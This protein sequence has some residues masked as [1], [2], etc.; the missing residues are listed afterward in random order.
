MITD[1][2]EEW[3]T[4][5]VSDSRINATLDFAQI[6]GVEIEIFEWRLVME[7]TLATVSA[8]WTQ[9]FRWHGLVD[10]YFHEIHSI[11]DEIT[12]QSIFAGAGNNVVHIVQKLQKSK[13]ISRVDVDG[14]NGWIGSQN[15]SPIG[16]SDVFTYHNQM[17]GI[18]L[19]W[20][21]P[22]F[23]M[24]RQTAYFLFVFRFD[25]LSTGSV[26]EKYTRKKCQMKKPSLWWIDLWPHSPHT[27]RILK[28]K[29][30]CG[31]KTNAQFR[32]DVRVHVIRIFR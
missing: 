25:L 13:F 17:A 16:W 21:N 10:I 20:G 27:K 8:Q 30:I 6:L 4:I 12:T 1:A 23:T 14:S 7:I 24:V 5:T 3:H 18:T 29:Q 2:V 31:G 11:V 28:S 15:S 26:V 22:Q 32:D 9:L 19:V